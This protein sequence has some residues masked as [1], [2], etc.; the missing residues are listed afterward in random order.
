MATLG[1]YMFWLKSV[2]G[3]YRSGIGADPD[4]GMVPVTKLISPDGRHHVIHPGNDRG[5]ELSPYIV[6]Y[7]DRRLQLVSPFRS[8]PRA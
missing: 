8:V 5:E 7:F 1:Q 2:G 6:E 4:V 3:N